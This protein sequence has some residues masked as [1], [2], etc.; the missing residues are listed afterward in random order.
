MCNN[1]LLDNNQVY[2][3]CYNMYRIGNLFRRAK[4]KFYCKFHWAEKIII[5]FH[6]SII[7]IFYSV[8]NINGFMTYIDTP[9]R[10]QHAILSN[11]S[12]PKEIEDFQR[13]TGGRD[14]TPYGNKMPPSTSQPRRPD[15]RKNIIKNLK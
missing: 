14:V 4:P 8:D 5:F 12:A 1:L 15:S 7:C 13:S 11:Q 3:N 6:K 9:T 2:F 10:R